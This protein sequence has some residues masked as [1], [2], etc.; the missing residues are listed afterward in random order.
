[1]KYI[2]VGGYYDNKEI[3]IKYPLEIVTMVLPHKPCI[4]SVEN[5]AF[6]TVDDVYMDT[7]EYRR[8]KCRDGSYF[9]KII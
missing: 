8:T 6:P 3:D 7:V 4:L 2:L 5:A 9:Y 1:M